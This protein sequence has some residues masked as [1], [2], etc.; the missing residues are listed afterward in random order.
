MIIS[1]IKQIVNF[2]HNKGIPLPMLRDPK[3]NQ[4][5]V[6][7]TMFIASFTVCIAALIGSLVQLLGGLEYQNALWLFSITGAFYLGRKFQSK[8]DGVSIE[9]NDES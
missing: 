9:K 4:P 6:T 2:M 7:L 1:K 3:T 8:K 5:S